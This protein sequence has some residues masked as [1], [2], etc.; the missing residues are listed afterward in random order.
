[1]FGVILLELLAVFVGQWLVVVL[2]VHHEYHEESIVVVTDHE[3][4]LPPIES[5]LT[6]GGRY[7]LRIFR[8]LLRLASLVTVD[9]K[10]FDWRLF[11]VLDLHEFTLDSKDAINYVVFLVLLEAVLDGD[12]AQVLDRLDTDL[13]VTLDAASC[14]HACWNVLDQLAN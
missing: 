1:M 4:V 5:H 2:Q 14:N 13:G 9:V 3:V 6:E 8:L 7:F 11:D 12:L 10:E